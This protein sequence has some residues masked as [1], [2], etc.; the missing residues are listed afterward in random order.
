MTRN[1]QFHDRDYAYKGTRCT[2][3]IMRV[4]CVI[5]EPNNSHFVSVICFKK[6]KKN[7]KTLHHSNIHIPH[8]FT[9]FASK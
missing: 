3:L 5:P 7:K 9:Y 6:Q 1:P 4:S 2:V 8:T